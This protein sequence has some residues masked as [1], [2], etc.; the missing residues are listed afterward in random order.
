MTGT[1]FWSDVVGHILD[2]VFSVV[3]ALAATGAWRHARHAHRLLN[4]EETV[5]DEDG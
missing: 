3:A 1:M 2:G 4:G 5:S